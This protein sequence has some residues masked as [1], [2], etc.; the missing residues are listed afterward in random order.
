ME[1]EKEKSWAKAHFKQ[2]GIEYYNPDFIDEAV[3]KRAYF[4]GWEECER[5]HA[6]IKKQP[7]KFPDWF[8]ALVVLFSVAFLT[9]L[10]MYIIPQIIKAI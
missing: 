2:F 5:Q 10:I 9:L 1:T 7:V 6:N 4:K 8:K 3:F